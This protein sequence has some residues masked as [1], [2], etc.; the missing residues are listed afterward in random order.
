MRASGQ[1]ANLALQLIRL[2]RIQPTEILSNSK[3]FAGV[4]CIEIATFYSI[5]VTPIITDIS[6]LISAQYMKVITLDVNVKEQMVTLLQTLP[7]IK[8]IQRLVSQE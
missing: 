3:A 5:P 7:G 2:Q 4:L 8:I 6:N 1:W